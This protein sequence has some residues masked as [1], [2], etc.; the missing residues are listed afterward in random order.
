MVSTLSSKSRLSCAIAVLLALT[1][2]AAAYGSAQEE[3]NKGIEFEKA[4]KQ[5]EAI[6]AYESAIAADP[7]FPDPYLNLGAL[8]FSKKE[9][10]KAIGNFKKYTQL[11]PDSYDGLKNLGYACVE[12]SDIPSGESAFDAALKLKPKEPELLRGYANLYYKADKWDKAIE[13]FNLYIA[14]Q[15]ND[16]K[17]LTS[18]G[19]SYEG[20]GRDADAVATYGKALKADPNYSMAHFQLGGIY[21]AQKDYSKAAEEFRKSSSLDKSHWKSYYN[22][23]I[24]R[25]ALETQEDYIEAYHAYA[26]FMKLTSGM[27]SSQVADMRQKAQNILGELKSYFETEGID[28]QQ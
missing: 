1:I 26:T 4:G 28:Y 11:K 23:G 18:L 25:Q 14:E 7:A 12:A 20:A 9:Y 2:S 3:F 8:Q 13:R 6:N 17:A 24:A 27:K 21:L 19:R 22:L 15:P 16:A 5:A 10:Q